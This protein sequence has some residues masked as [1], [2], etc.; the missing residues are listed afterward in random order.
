[1]KETGENVIL[2]YFSVDWED[3]SKIYELNACNLM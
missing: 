1:M 2:D 3:L